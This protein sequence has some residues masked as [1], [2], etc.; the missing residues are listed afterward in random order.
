MSTDLLTLS[1][2]LALAL[3][4]FTTS[5]LRYDVVALLALLAATLTGVVPMD[6]AF[7]GFGHP[8]VI[9]VAAVLVIS[10]GFYQSGVVDALSNL[11][12]RVGKRPTLQV[13][14]LTLS[15]AVLSSFMNNVGALA[16]MLPVALKVARTHNL[17][18]SKLL[19]P[20]AF[21]SLLGG[22]TTLIGTPPNVIIASLSV[23]AGL[24][25]FGF[26]DFARVGGGVALAGIAY[27]TSI[28]WRF[29]PERKGQSSPEER[30]QV[31]TYMGELRVGEKSKALG[32]MLRELNEAV[33]VKV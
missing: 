29:L 7:G 24:T 26:F 19:M 1:I 2:I 32:L 16:L 8:A 17:A 12:M 33:K 9:T 4:G 3:V 30:F 14:A 11:V 25:P 31:A 10:R 5:W 27:I 28:G 21:A 18:A 15:V 23:E 13:L 6:R 22:L 20:L